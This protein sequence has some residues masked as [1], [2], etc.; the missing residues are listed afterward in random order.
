MSAS[1][2]VVV[3]AAGGGR[4]M[5][6]VRK[7]YAELL[8]IPML[9]RALDP[10]LAHPAVVRVVVALPEED[11][12][13][14]PE[15]LRGIDPRIELVSGGAERSDSVRSGLEALHRSVGVVLVHDA[16]RPLVTLEVIDRVYQ[17]AVAG[18]GA[19]AAVPLT[20]TVK[21]VDAE[22]LVLRT[23]DRSRLRAAQTPQGFPRAM[24]V[25][26]H[27]RAGEDGIG[28]TDDAALVERY[29]GRVIIVPGDADN[30]KV[31]TARDV[32]LAE[33][34]LRSRGR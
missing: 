27:R 24:L 5:G 33:A 30:L 18:F 20:D 15:W 22:G 3:A 1:A 17:A 11:L 8:G 32:I 34:V 25:E 19:V 9:R 23:P 21:E 13:A 14:P 7:Q 29:G 2:G 31:T 16:A 12:S 26:A 4:R 6:G 28:A 10:F